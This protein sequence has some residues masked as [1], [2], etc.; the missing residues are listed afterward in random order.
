M[1]MLFISEYRF[2]TLAQ[3]SITDALHAI[4]VKVIYSRRVQ[5]FSTA[6]IIAN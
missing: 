6:N 2:E 3:F 4:I 5:I 1:M